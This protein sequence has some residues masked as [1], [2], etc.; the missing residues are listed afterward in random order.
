ML[1]FL[2]QFFMFIRAYFVDFNNF[3]TLLLVLL[4]AGC[5]RFLLNVWDG[6][7]WKSKI[8]FKEKI[9]LEYVNDFY[10]GVLKTTYLRIFTYFS[11]GDV[12]YSVFS[13][14]LTHLSLS[15]VKKPM[16]L[17]TCTKV[18]TFLLQNFL[19]GIISVTSSFTNIFYIE[20]Y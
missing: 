12:T 1:I 18:N 19:N 9:V 15:G 16:H 2:L 6:I 4:F 14:I 10:A 8:V 5:W 3:A 17:R 11:A 20:V 13:D 7:R